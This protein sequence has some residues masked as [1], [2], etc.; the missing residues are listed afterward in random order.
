VEIAV[1]RSWF[2]TN[3]GPNLLSE[4]FIGAGKTLAGKY[5]QTALIVSH[6]GVTTLETPKGEV[7]ATLTSAGRL[8]TP[9]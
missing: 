6:Q 1:E 8:R 7:W 4:D 5:N 9:R 3:G 2:F